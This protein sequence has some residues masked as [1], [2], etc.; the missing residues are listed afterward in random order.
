MV[1][2]D[3]SMLYKKQ[4][5]ILTYP[6]KNFSRTVRNKNNTTTKV[7]RGAS[8]FNLEKRTSTEIKKLPRVYL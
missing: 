4:K 3:V 5:K 1:V 6:F 8:S 7:V 2:P